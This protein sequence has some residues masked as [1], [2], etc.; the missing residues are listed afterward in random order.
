MTHDETYAMLLEAAQSVLPD[1]EEP[2][3]ADF[4]ASICC[5]E[6]NFGAE[7]IGFNYAGIDA[8]G[9]QPYTEAREK[10]SGDMHKYAKFSS[11]KDCMRSLYYLISKSEDYKIE[12]ERYRRARDFA[13]SSF[14]Q[15]H[16]AVY[17]PVDPGWGGK[18]LRI[19]LTHKMLWWACVCVLGLSV[20][21]TTVTYTAKDGTVIEY[22][23][24]YGKHIHF[25][26]DP[27][28]GKMVYDTDY[29]AALALADRALGLAAGAAGGKGQ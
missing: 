19:M 4:M 9:A 13:R 3:I 7:T 21:C 15:E 24:P 18:V 16:G 12:R 8:W 1:D 11:I 23:A 17:C 5:H 6:S 25:E 29:D 14:I 10:S 26:Y 27:K 22:Q 28:T 2:W 20:G